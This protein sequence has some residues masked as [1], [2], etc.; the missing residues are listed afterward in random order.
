MLDLFL[1]IISHNLIIMFAQIFSKRYKEIESSNFCLQFPLKIC[2]IE[3]QQKKIFDELF[4]YDSKNSQLDKSKDDFKFEINNESDLSKI[5]N[6][7]LPESKGEECFIICEDEP[8]KGLP[9][10]DC[11]ELFSLK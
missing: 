6:V 1:P 3:T 2:E 11:L 9:I 10:S 5:I 7:Q 4:F 8:P